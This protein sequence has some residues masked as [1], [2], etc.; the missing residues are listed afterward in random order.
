MSEI[1]LH[2]RYALLQYLR[3]P[4]ALFFSVA[5]PLGFYLL[6]GS[7]FAAEGGAIQGLTPNVVLFAAVSGSYV[8]LAIGTVEDRQEGVLKRLRGT[9][10]QP[11]RYLVALAL[12]AV[13]VALVVALLTVGLGMAVFDLQVIPRLLPAAVLTLLVGLAVLSLL[14]L[15]TTAIIPNVQAAT[16]VTNA[17]TFPLLFASGLFL[18][19]EMM[20]GWLTRIASVFPLLPLGRAMRAAFDPATSGLGMAWG[21]LAFVAAWGLAG[22]V[23]AARFFRWQPWTARARG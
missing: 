12:S 2:T 11:W 4:T 23:V 16:G 6:F 19:L 17:I 10:L 7:L 13:L 1:L 5:F 18:P 15:A 21:D 9:P 8:G 14:S 22:L 20:P 3:N